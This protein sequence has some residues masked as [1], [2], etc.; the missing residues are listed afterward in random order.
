LRGHDLGEEAWEL[1][2]VVSPRIVIAGCQPVMDLV[3]GLGPSANQPAVARTGVVVGVE[4][5]AFV[6][7][8]HRQAAPADAAV[9]RPVHL[10]AVVLADIAVVVSHVD[11]FRWISS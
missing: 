4:D 8:L 9:E 1:D 2:R 11:S 6:G 5:H 7:H 10:E 3:E